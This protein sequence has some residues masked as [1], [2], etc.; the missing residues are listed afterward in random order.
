[1]TDDDA[2]DD[3]HWNDSRG[4]I[5]IVVWGLV[6]LSNIV[7][8]YSYRYSDPYGSY[9]NSYCDED[10]WLHHCVVLE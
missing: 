1:M 6:G 2:D 8:S 9:T 10:D 4:V 7:I 3:Y 5:V